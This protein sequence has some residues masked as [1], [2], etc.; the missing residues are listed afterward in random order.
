MPPIGIQTP[1][2]FC[3][4]ASG[5]CDQSFADVPPTH[6][7]V[8]YSSKPEVIGSAIEE[9]VRLLSISSPDLKIK[10]WRDLPIAG[11]IIF[12]QICKS[13]R[14][15]QVAVIDVTTM[16]FN[17]MFELGYALGLG[18]PVVAIRDTSCTLDAME[19]EALGLIDTLGYVNFENSQELASKLPDAIANAKMPVTQAYTPSRAQPLYLLRSPIVT[20]GLI[21]VISTVKK[22][23]LRFRVY[24]PKEQ[25]R[26][27]LQDAFKQVKTSLGVSVYL[28]SSWRKGATVHNARG[29]FV[30]G[31]A[32]ASGCSVF[33]LQEGPDQQPI[34]YR[35][36]VQRHSDAAQV[37]HLMSPFIKGLYEEIQST[38]FV[39][40]TLPLRPL[41]T[42]DF[43]D[44]AAENEINA[45]KSYFLPTA[46][47]NDAKR[48]H[49]RLVVGR[50]GA[51]KT[52]IFYGVRSA[53]W[54]S[55]S[56]LVLDLKPEG[57]QFLTLRERLLSSISLGL[58]EHVLTAFWNYILLIELAAKIVEQDSRFASKQPQR[59]E[60]Y[61]KLR[62]L[63]EGEGEAEQGD[64]SDRLL[65][66]V[67][68]V[69]L[70][71]DEIESLIGSGQISKLI[72]EKDIKEVQAVLSEYLKF[73]EGVWILIDNLDK[74]WPVNGATKE[75]ILI[76]RSLME[77]TRKLQR[78]LERNNVECRAIVFIRN[79][80]YEHLLG[81]TPDKGKDNTILLDW[82]DEEVF[83]LLIHRRMMASTRLEQPF[84]EMWPMFFESYIKGEHSFSYI[85]SRTMM[86]PRDLISF[87]RQCIN[88][89]VNRGNTKVLEADILQAEKQYSEDQLQGIFFELSDTKREFAELP[90]AF[91]GSPSLLDR[92]EIEAKVTGFGVP[93]AIVE[94]AVQILLW[95][96]FLG[97]I[98]TDGEEKY[99]HMYQYGVQRMLREA[100]PGTRWVIHPAFRSVLGCEAN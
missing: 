89:A 10:T 82:T 77:A 50:K 17:L 87:L 92:N 14:F 9:A 40:I 29:A 11:Q 52:A 45:L 46:Q 63:I 67:D 88:V 15:T 20:D 84:E 74:S 36:V 28:L 76:I 33:V 98:G 68:R 58:Q 30:A 6:A 1:P 47:Y 81:E 91:I 70:R 49:A 2:E 61:E 95:F 21:K 60:L 16:N 100:T 3:Q 8:Y 39:P 19:F 26:L 62:R 66:L 38:R 69:L 79:D 34:D 83:K 73:K 12:C 99:A 32:M 35:D 27:S 86:R 75:D 43:G 31:L 13:Q 59:F 65:L 96:G 56:Q 80:V 53:F 23:G 93:Q 24:D 54:S 64:F 78:Q 4:Y 44:V 57:H 37:P 71:K 48:G 94:E 42:L 85:L 90:Y 97:M 18:V 55:Q 25:P 5:P 22:S 51:G 7:H 41:E 72:Y